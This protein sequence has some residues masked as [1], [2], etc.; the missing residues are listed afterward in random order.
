MSNAG[1]EASPLLI[2]NM[3]QGPLRDCDESFSPS[4]AGTR[5]R[6]WL[7]TL[8]VNC[9]SPELAAMMIKA[10]SQRERPMEAIDANPFQLV[11]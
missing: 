5:G 1:L 10:V 9:E 8:R 7:A 3:P 2:G 11:S 4:R 6:L